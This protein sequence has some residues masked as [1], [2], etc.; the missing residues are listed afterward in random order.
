MATTLDLQALSE[1]VQANTVKDTAIADL[2][3]ALKAEVADLKAQLAA[4]PKTDAEKDA[5]SIAKVLKA[6]IDQSIKD[7]QIIL[8]ANKDVIAKVK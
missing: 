7:K 8:D 2:I 6:A 5:D 4:Y 3:Q 1:T